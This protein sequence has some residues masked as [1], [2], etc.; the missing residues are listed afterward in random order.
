MKSISIALA[1]IGLAI[2]AVPASAQAQQW[3]PVAARQNIEA[4]IDRGLRSGALTRAEAQRLRNEYRQLVQLERRYR[5]S[6]GRFTA[7]ERREI[8]Q[9]YSA[10]SRRLTAQTNHRYAQRRR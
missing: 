5:Q 1:G 8:D 7:A 2:A 3:Q 6:G 4:Q 9:R 10:L